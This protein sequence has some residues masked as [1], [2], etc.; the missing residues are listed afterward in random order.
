MRSSQTGHHHHEHQLQQQ[1]QQ[2]S[3]Y[4]RSLFSGLLAVSQAMEL[5]ARKGPSLDVLHAILPSLDD[6]N[7]D[8]AAKVHA[9]T[10][11]L[12]CFFSPVTL[13]FPVFPAW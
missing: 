11:D 7:A 9:R 2:H 10:H 6:R 1:Q 13:V 12:F 8:V 5:A 3:L 4:V